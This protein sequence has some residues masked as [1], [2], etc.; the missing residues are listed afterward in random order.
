V[1]LRTISPMDWNAIEKSV[2]KTGRLLVVD[3]SNAT[4][5]VAGE[6]VARISIKLFSA[7]KMATMRLAL[8]DYPSPSS[9]ALTAGYYQRAEHIIDAVAQLLSRDLRSQDVVT[10]RKGPHDVPGDWFK[11]P[12]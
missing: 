12:F 1:D 9:P 2:Q 4:N 7:L 10:L 11:G 6:I 5:S 3:T 8:P